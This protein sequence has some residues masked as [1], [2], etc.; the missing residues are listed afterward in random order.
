MGIKIVFDRTDETFAGLREGIAEA[1]LAIALEIEANAKRRI[2]TGPKT[3]RLYGRGIGTTNRSRFRAIG[4]RM[5]QAS[6]AGQSPA[7]E[8]GGLANSIQAR[9]LGERSAEVTV[10][11]EY[12]RVLEETRNRPFLQPAV[13]AAVERAPAI[14]RAAVEAKV[15]G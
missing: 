10:G 5:H 2:V 8:T 3:G 9:R 11:K 6:A 7:N 14:V 12:G 1:T 4:Y 15:P 13:E